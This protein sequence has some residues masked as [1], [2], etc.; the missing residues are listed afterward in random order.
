MEGLNSRVLMG[1]FCYP[2]FIITV[3]TSQRLPEG[4][5]ATVLT[6]ENREQNRERLPSRAPSYILQGRVAFKAFTPLLP[7]RTQHESRNQQAL[8]LH[9]LTVYTC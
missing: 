3:C 9:F 7:F 5:L 6:P 1:L 8:E 2:L 4:L